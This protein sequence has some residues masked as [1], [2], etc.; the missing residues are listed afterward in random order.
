MKTTKIEVKTF[1][2]IQIEYKDFQKIFVKAK[3][4]LV[5]EANGA[6]KDFD[7]TD[8][9]IGN[10]RNCFK[11]LGDTMAMSPSCHQRCK[12]LEYIVRELGFDGIQHFGGFYKDSEVYTLTVYNN[13]SDL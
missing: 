7:L 1:Y 11:L 3:G 12:D 6:F 2:T 13:G 5:C 10:I 8:T 4:S 9:T